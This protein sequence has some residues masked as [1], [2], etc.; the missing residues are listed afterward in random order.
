MEQRERR[1]LSG[2]AEAVIRRLPGVSA[3]RV[4]LGDDARI[5]QVHVLAAPDRTA[6]ALVELATM[7]CQLTGALDCA[8]RRRCHASGTE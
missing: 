4:E 8:R 5:D 2:D 7:T 1:S 3:V 6:R